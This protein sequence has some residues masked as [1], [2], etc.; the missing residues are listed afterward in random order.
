MKKLI[1]L[2][3]KMGRDIE[4]FNLA[5]YVTLLNSPKR[6]LTINFLGGVARGLGFALGATLFAAI[7][8]YILQRIMVLN[9][10]LI[11][12]FIS[13]IVRIVQERL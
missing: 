9:L 8:I 10:P 5:E 4:R 13:D 1:Y 6:F 11:G 3:Q 12:D 7:F 2:I